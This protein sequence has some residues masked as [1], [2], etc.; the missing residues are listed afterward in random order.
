VTKRDLS[1]LGL[2]GFMAVAGSAHF[3]FPRSYEQIV[4]HVMGN[5]AFWV[6]ASGLAEFG[7]A[8]LLAGRR[9]AAL[10]GWA[11]AALFVVVFPAN[12]QMAIDGGIPGAGFPAS[13]ATL[14]WVRLPLQI[15]LI[16]WAISVAR[17]HRASA[18]LAS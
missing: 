18:R 14:A 5:P 3:V 2:A 13:S 10:G 9:T 12:V 15:P 11:T 16:V 7:C 8:A 17:S 1:R 4:P 6:R